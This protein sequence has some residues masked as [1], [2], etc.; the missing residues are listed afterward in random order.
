MVRTNSN[1]L[2]HVFG[3]PHSGIIVEIYEDYEC[4]NCGKAFRDMKALRDYFKNE[5]CFIYKHFPL[6]KM[7]PSALL[8]A[9]IVESCGLQK[10]YLQAHDLILQCQDYLEYG[11][12]GIIRLLTKDFSV[13][14]E[15]LS[16]DLEDG[17]I[18]SKINNDIKTGKLLGIMNTPS[19]FINGLIYK[20]AITYD[21]IACTLKEKM[22]EL[23]SRST[24]DQIQNRYSITV[25][26]GFPLQPLH[27]I[28]T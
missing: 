21:S 24:L 14:E 20:G 10:K 13:S 3:N 23:K 6:I 17:A 11:L 7:H 2:N 9:Q 26:P 28:N 1:K 27:L 8:A 5:I 16:K 25:P 12:G 22:Y 18:S 15:Q 4:E 19:L